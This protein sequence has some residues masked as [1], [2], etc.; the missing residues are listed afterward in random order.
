MNQ[1]R[2]PTPTT[3][4]KEHQF[5]V[6]IEGDLCLVEGH[7]GKSPIPAK[8]LPQIEPPPT[9]C[10]F[11]QEIRVLPSNF[12]F[13]DSQTKKTLALFLDLIPTH[14]GGLPRCAQSATFNV[15]RNKLDHWIFCQRNAYILKVKQ[16]SWFHT[17]TLWC[18]MDIPPEGWVRTLGRGLG[19]PSYE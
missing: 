5:V 3:L 11:E 13:F 18:R 8:C 1:S 19:K 12:N 10:S 14:T 17:P 15:E 16:D 4:Q 6:P 7:A 2:P 9:L